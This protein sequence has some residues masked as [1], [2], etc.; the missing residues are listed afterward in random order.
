[1]AIYNAIPRGIKIRFR[2]NA[3]VSRVKYAASNQT[4]TPLQHA[5][6]EIKDLVQSI[7]PSGANN[8][9][10]VILQRL[11]SLGLVPQGQV[12]EVDSYAALLKVRSLLRTPSKLRQEGTNLR[13]LRTIGEYLTNIPPRSGEKEAIYDNFVQALYYPNRNHKPFDTNV[14]LDRLLF[15]STHKVKQENLATQL[16]LTMVEDIMRFRMMFSMTPYPYSFVSMGSKRWTS[17]RTMPVQAIKTYSSYEF[18]ALASDEDVKGITDYLRR[19]QEQSQPRDK[20][21][22]LAQ[23]LNLTGGFGAESYTITGAPKGAL[24][25]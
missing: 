3:S 1:M 4:N 22:L 23:L 12:K 24:Y 11:R 14:A 9:R 13:I 16:G 5:R 7:S 21:I 17:L 6:E 20:L 19:I 18:D 2:I 8:V 25:T 10:A 15:D